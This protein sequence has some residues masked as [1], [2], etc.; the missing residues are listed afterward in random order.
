M[1]AVVV[2]VRLDGRDA[3]ALEFGLQE[4]VRRRLPLQALHAYEVPT[5]AGLPP[6]LFPSAITRARRAAQTGAAAA[7]AEAVS[8]V[9]GGTTVATSVAAVEGATVPALLE[10]AEEAALLV[11]GRR[12]SNGFV[13]AV[14][15]SVS[16]AVLRHA[17]APVA[18]VPMQPARVP[19]RWLSSRVVVGMDGSTAAE[20]ALDWGIAQA[21][22]WGSQLRP[23][24][25]LPTH[26][27]EAATRLLLGQVEEQLTEAAASDIEVRVQVLRGSPAA[28]LLIEVRPE[29]LLVLGGRDHGR[30]VEVVVG[31]TTQEVVQA[32]PCPVVVVRAGQVRRQ[33]ARAGSLRTPWW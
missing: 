2:G 24:L 3:P 22:E 8:H 11:V 21:R 1:R 26:A 13:Q 19:D 15:G 30:L 14:L 17:P 9:P 27:D 4:A 5:V 16:A 10:A 18:V 25:V 31:S 33:V 20:A 28:H 32:A 12:K 7:L 29:D 23:V 6:A